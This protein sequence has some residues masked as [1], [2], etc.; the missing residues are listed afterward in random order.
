MILFKKGDTQYTLL[1]GVHSIEW[2][3][4]NGDTVIKS[5]DTKSYLYSVH[6]FKTDDI[7]IINVYN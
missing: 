5:V 3:D 6:R 1:N 4:L 7:R 2:D